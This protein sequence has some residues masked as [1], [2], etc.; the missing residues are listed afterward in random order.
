M[1][2][3]AIL[4]GAMWSA[5]GGGQRYEQIA[6]KL[7]N[8]LPSDTTI[9]F[10]SFLPYTTPSQFFPSGDPRYDVVIVGFPSF[11]KTGGWKEVL[12]L[13]H[14]C[15]LV[16]DICDFWRGNEMIEGSNLVEDD[17]E[18]A[19]DAQLL[20]AVNPSLISHYLH[21]Q[22]PFYIIPNGLRDEF[23]QEWKFPIDSTVHCYW[24]GSH[25]RGQT[26]LDVETLIELPK[27]FPQ[28]R[29]HY[30]FA[31]DIVT[32]DFFR[33]LPN[34]DFRGSPQGIPMDEILKEIRLPAIGLVP[35]KPFNTAAFHADPIKI[36][37]YWALGF[38]VVATNCWSSLGQ[39]TTVHLCF[40]SVVEQV[41]AAI[42]SKLS[43]GNLLVEPPSYEEK[44]MFSW[45]ERART[46]ASV[47]QSFIV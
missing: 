18:L 28:I 34:V 46:Y 9:E 42:G 39:R 21:L 1:K 37:E 27:R 20:V 2:R 29:F 4:S 44:L 8:F 7:K 11:Y 13:S 24:W 5:T 14:R 36:Y 22:K 43:S 40:G 19:R 41:S 15:L 47:L 17:D 12:Q 23:L 38:H 25:Y 30:F 3:V 31:T 45:T 6:R 35:F 16:Y 10:F 26:W 32:E 33:N